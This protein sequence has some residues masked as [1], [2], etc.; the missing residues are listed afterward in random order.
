MRRSSG[1]ITGRR[2]G[3]GRWVSMV[4]RSVSTVWCSSTPSAARPLGTSLADRLWRPSLF[5]GRPRTIA[6]GP[7]R[8]R[9]LGRPDRT[10][11]VR[12]HQMIPAAGAAYLH[13]V[14]GELVVAGSQQDQFL[15]CS[16]RPRHSTEMVAEDP[17][18]QRQLFLAADRAHHR[19][20][21]PMEFRGTQQVGVGVADLRDAGASRIDL[22]QQGPAPKRVVHHLSLQSHG[23]QSTSAMRRRRRDGVTHVSAFHIWT[24]TMNAQLLRSSTWQRRELLALA[25][26]TAIASIF[27]RFLTA[28]SPTD[29]CRSPNTSIG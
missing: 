21:L 3:A 28:R 10:E 24:A 17:R 12:L 26:R 1:G 19:T 29:S 5:T 16:R 23:D 14:Y 9:A 6:R 4:G 8:T 18:H 11:H 2:G 7:C 27:A 13:H 25:R 22:G 20:G 15:S